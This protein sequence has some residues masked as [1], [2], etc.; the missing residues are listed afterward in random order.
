MNLENEKQ[1]LGKI[2][3]K[4]LKKCIVT[5]NQTKRFDPG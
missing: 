1:V 2:L 4:F 5:K 3:I